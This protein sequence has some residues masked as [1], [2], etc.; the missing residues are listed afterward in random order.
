MPMPPW[1]SPNSLSRQRE[2]STRGPSVNGPVVGCDSTSDGTALT[3]SPVEPFRRCC[4]CCSAAAATKRQ[5]SQEALT[6]CVLRLALPLF[7]LQPTEQQCGVAKWMLLLLLL[8]VARC[9]VT[10]RSCSNSWG[11]GQGA[12]YADV[13]DRP[14]PEPPSFHPLCLLRIARPAKST[15]WEVWPW[16]E[17][18][19]TDVRARYVVD[20]P[21]VVGLVGHLNCCRCLP[22]R[23]WRTNALESTSGLNSPRVDGKA[24]VL[25]TWPLKLGQRDEATV[26]RSR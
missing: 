25:R 5:P 12:T 15:K 4:C 13:I 1:P 18:L 8:L 2:H 3:T 23:H 20:N 16:T 19:S 7:R 21:V 14:C 24:A 26:C 11:N 9:T 17:P 6:R 10:I 22:A